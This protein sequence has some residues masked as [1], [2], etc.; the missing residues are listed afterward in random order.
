MSRPIAYGIDFGTSNSSIAVA[1]DD[2]AEIGV[3]NEQGDTVM[4]SIVYV[5]ATRNRL[6]GLDAVDNYIRF[7]ADPSRARLMSSLKTFLTDRT[8]KQTTAAWGER[9]T[10]PDLVAIILRQLKRA[11]DR[12]LGA[13]VKRVVLGHPVLFAGASGPDFE[14]L[15][16][17]ALNQLDQSAR[18]AGFEEV[19][20][21]DEPT[22]ALMG[23]ELTEGLIM[24]VDFGGGTFDVSIIELTPEA[25]DVLAIHGAA[26]G[27][28]LFD[29]LLF[30]AKVASELHLDRQYVI[31]GKRQSV[32]TVLRHMRTLHEII[33]MVGD[34]SVHRAFEYVSQAGGKPL[35]TVEEIIYGG[36]AYNFFRAIEG[37]KISLSS[38]PEATILFRRPRI[39]VSVPVLRSEFEALVLRNLDRVDDQIE[40]A[41]KEA[42][43]ASD[44]VDLVIR[45]GGSSRIPAFVERLAD[46][47]GEGKLAERDAFSTVALGLGIR[48]CELWG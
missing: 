35:E 38:A 40:R 5:D 36:H 16:D 42:N 8:F 34:D 2:G 20:F 45:T 32:P 31:N 47:F 39:S 10:M 43:A 24:A 21:L 14:Q 15:Q 48:A 30:D 17:H 41:L 26:I 4:P 28:E 6:S 44:E 12:R 11:N 33:S 18:L 3:V 9:Y 1:F 19:A 22:A 7:A 46:R 25:G 27:G 23:E 29:S 37:A 13:D